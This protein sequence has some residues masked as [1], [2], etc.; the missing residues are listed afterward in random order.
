MRFEIEIN[1]DA[2]VLLSDVG[3]A[4]TFEFEIKDS[5]IES[6]KMIPTPDYLNHFEKKNILQEPLIY[7]YD[8]SQIHYFPYPANVN[9][10]PIYSMFH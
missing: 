2:F 1:F 8:K 10:L 5:T 7:S 3:D 6:D 4:A 9:D